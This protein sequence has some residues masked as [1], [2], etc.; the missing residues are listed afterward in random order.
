MLL[1]LAAQSRRGLWATAHELREHAGGESGDSTRRELASLVRE[2]FLRRKSDGRGRDHHS[3][4]CANE[5]DEE[6]R[7]PHDRLNDRPTIAQTIAPRSFKR[8]PHDRPLYGR[9]RAHA[10]DPDLPSGEV[11][12]NQN[13]LSV[14]VGVQ[15]EGTDGRTDGSKKFAEIARRLVGSI[16]S[17][18]N[19]PLPVVEICVAKFFAQVAEL[20]EPPTEREV[21]RYFGA[22]LHHRE[23]KWTHRAFR[24]TIPGKFLG[25]VCTCKR[26]E[27][28]RDVEAKSRD[29]RAFARERERELKRDD[30]AALPL[31][32]GVALFERLRKETRR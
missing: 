22:A 27:Q 2:G 4:Y 19:E 15:G 12:T 17:D 24:D 29:A 5:I 32:E 14:R 13:R 18:W 8:S 1:Y 23:G 9:E 16:A 7:S 21:S 31:A 30:D 25:C 11:V 20:D 3:L 10:R 26:F 6:K 28:W